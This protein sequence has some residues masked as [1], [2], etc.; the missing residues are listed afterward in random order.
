MKSI[1]LRT[2]RQSYVWMD[3][4]VDLSEKELRQLEDEIHAHLNTTLNKGSESSRSADVPPIPGPVPSFTDEKSS[5]TPVKEQTQ[6]SSEASLKS[7]AEVLPT[8]RL[9]PPRRRLRERLKGLGNKL[10]RAKL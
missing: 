4:W 2:H 7:E 6:S 8:E 1:Y 3:E 9:S 5:K 10:L